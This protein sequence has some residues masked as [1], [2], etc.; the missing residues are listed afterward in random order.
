[1]IDA[2]ELKREIENH[3]M[4]FLPS[5]DEKS[6]A[7]CESIRY[8]LE[9]PGKRVRPILLLAAAEFSGGNVNEAL[10]YAIAVEYIHTYSL[11]HDDLPCMDDDDIRRGQP[12]NHVKFGEAM[13]LLA[14][15]GLLTS[16][17]ELMCKNMFHYFKR[18]DELKKHID[19]VY[20]I[21][22]AAGVG[23]M[24]AGQVSDLETNEKE[25]SKELLDFIHLNKTA[26][27]IRAA[28]CA[29][30]Y[31]GGASDELI[32]AFSRY[33][34]ELGVAFQIRD[35]M[36]DKG[37]YVS[38]LGEEKAMIEIERRTNEAI[39]TIEPFSA[40]EPFFVDLARRLSDRTE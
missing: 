25:V 32:A 14:G 8:S 22:R 23:G 31:I 24:I 35:D 11:I 5:V 18:S 37:Q 7:L 2:K 4:D 17:F 21:A 26:A 29:G 33:G 1:M 36:L 15:D 13:A 6:E 40:G 28:V 39:K 3:V 27:L 30:G 34:E 10:P 19:A 12:S 16:A 38:A 9:A 20:E